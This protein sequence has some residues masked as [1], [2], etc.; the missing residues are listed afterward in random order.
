MSEDLTAYQDSIEKSLGAEAWREALSASDMKLLATM[1]AAGA[2][3]VNAELASLLTDRRRQRVTLPVSKVVNFG[4]QVAE[5]AVDVQ[6]VINGRSV[7]LVT[8]PRRVKHTQDS[9]CVWADEDGVW[10]YQDGLLLLPDDESYVDPDDTGAWQTWYVL[11]WNQDLNAL[12]IE[13]Q[14]TILLPGV[15]FYQTGDRLFLRQHPGA[16]GAASLIVVAD[17]QPPNIAAFS[18]RSEL[19]SAWT[20]SSLLRGNPTTARLQ[21]WLDAE[22]GTVR[23]PVSGTITQT[24]SLEHGTRYVCAGQDWWVPYDCTELDPGTYVQ[25]GQPFGNA[26]TLYTGTAAGWW[27]GLDWS[28]GLSLDNVCPFSGLHIPPGVIP[29]TSVTYNGVVRVQLTLQ[30]D[31]VVLAAWQQWCLAA[32]QAAYP[33]TSPLAQL[34][35]FTEAG[36][37][38]LIDGLQYFLDLWWNSSITVLVPQGHVPPALLQELRNRMPVTSVLIVQMPAVT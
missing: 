9:A 18:L 14:G 8:Y 7:H 30:G 13:I 4:M 34:C 25:K 5:S 29:A 19:P 15:D 33:S 27:R 23:A 31:P 36:Q 20:S 1:A 11:P 3:R 22:L 37:T 28:S 38:K 32:E 21:V 35:G 10:L 2:A 17:Q 26:A 12:Y 24:S 6:T 16:S